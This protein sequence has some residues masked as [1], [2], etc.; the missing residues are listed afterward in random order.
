MMSDP[1]RPAARARRAARAAGA[2][3]GEALL[4]GRLL[5][6]AAQSFPASSK[7]PSSIR[8]RTF[9]ALRSTA[10]GDGLVCA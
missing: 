6:Q 7:R 10:S 8:L 2:C 1:T 3:G 9:S 5:T 4:G